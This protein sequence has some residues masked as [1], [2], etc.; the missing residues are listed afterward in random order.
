MKFSEEATL[1]ERLHHLIRLKATGSPKQLARRLDMSK[2]NLFRLIYEMRNDGFPIAYDRIQERY[3]YE[4]EVVFEIKFQVVEQV[5][6]QRVMGG[7]FFRFFDDFFI[8][9]QILALRMGFFV[10]DNVVEGDY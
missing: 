2:R 1:R 6:A 8:Q 9:R 7:Q 10:S 5:E 4:K 3:Y